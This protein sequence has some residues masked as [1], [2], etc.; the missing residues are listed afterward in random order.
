MEL[1]SL[2]H[3]IQ[4]LMEEKKGSILP[5]TNHQR[6]LSILSHL[7]VELDTFL[8]LTL[9]MIGLGTICRIRLGN[10]FPAT[11]PANHNLAPIKN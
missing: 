7:A 4:C 9:P 1:D 2:I 10:L 5:C 11:F 8:Y 6:L 3:R